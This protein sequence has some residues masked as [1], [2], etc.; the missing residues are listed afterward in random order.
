[1]TPHQVLSLLTQDQTED[2]LL[3]CCQYLEVDR[4]ERAMRRGLEPLERR[5]LAYQLS[6]EFDLSGTDTDEES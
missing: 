3:A 5:Q 2:I 1:M 6:I 4:I